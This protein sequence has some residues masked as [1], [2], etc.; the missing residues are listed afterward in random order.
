V[1]AALT[2]GVRRAAGDVVICVGPGV[3]ATGEFVSPLVGTLADPTVAVAGPWGL[4]SDDQRHFEAAEPGAAVAAIDL[5][6]L[7]FRRSDGLDRG[8]LDER[9]EGDALLGAWWSLVLRDGAE[10]EPARRAAIVDVPVVRSAAPA[11]T[12]EDPAERRNRYRLIDRFG[13]RTDLA[14]P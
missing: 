1:A 9:F 13:N 10:D 12:D 7:A 3:V 6:C 11:D 14:N 4:A 5:A 8:P 2:A